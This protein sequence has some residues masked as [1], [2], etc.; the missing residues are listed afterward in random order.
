MS[1]FKKDGTIK[2][3]YMS[4][5]PL[6]ENSEL[7]HNTIIVNNEQYDYRC[8]RF[9][10]PKDREKY[11]V[12]LLDELGSGYKIWEVSA[13]TIAVDIINDYEILNIVKQ[14]D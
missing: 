13:D 3:V 8:R 6:I 10:V 7:C 1:C 5:V 4:L 12:A 11:I 14:A 9:E 2:K